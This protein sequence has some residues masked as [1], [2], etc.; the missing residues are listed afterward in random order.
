MATTLLTAVG[1]AIG[2]PVGGFVG[3]LLG[4][5]ID[6]EVF[7]PELEDPNDGKGPKID[8]FRFA[9]NA[10][11]SPMWRLVGEHNRVPGT[12]IWAGPLQVEKIE[13]EVGGKGGGGQTV[14]SYNY[15]IDLAVA[16]GEGPVAAWEEVRANNKFFWGNN[17]KFTAA[18]ADFDVTVDVVDGET[19]GRIT[20]P[21][22]GP[23]LKPFKSGLDVEIDG[24]VDSGGVNNGT[25][26][27][28]KSKK[29]LDGTSWIRY[30]NPD[31][32]AETAVQPIELEQL[33]PSFDPSK[34][35]EITFYDGTESQL[36][37]PL[38]ESVEG[39][40]MVPGFRGTAYFTIDKLALEPYGNL[41]PQWIIVAARTINE[42]TAGA[43]AQ[44]CERA[45]LT[46]AQYDVSAIPASSIVQG[47]PV[48]GTQTGARTLQPIMVAKDI[49]SQERNGVV[50]FFPRA[51]AEVVE[52]DPLDLAARPQGG[53]AETPFAIERVDSFEL[54]GRVSVKYRDVE[55]KY[56]EAMQEH[57]LR[58]K[59]GALV[60]NIDLGIVM[61]GEE[62][63]DIARRLAWLPRANRNRVTVR[64]PASYQRARENDLL[65]FTVL[66][67]PWRL[68]VQRADRGE[69]FSLVFETITE[70]PNL[71]AIDNSVADLPVDPDPNGDYIPPALQL[72]LKNAPG[73]TQSQVTT[74]GFFSAVF[75]FD[76]DAFFI[77][78]NVYRA[79][80]P[81][82][83]FFFVYEAPIAASVG[84]SST[85][86]AAPTDPELAAA[87][88]DRETTLTVEM[89]TGT[90]QSYELED[91]LAGAGRYLWGDEVIGAQRATF[92]GAGV[93]EL[94]ILL[95]GLRDTTDHMAHVAG[96]RVVHINAN[97]FDFIP[98]DSVVLGNSKVYKAV[99]FGAAEG[100]VEP[101]LFF[102]PTG[103]TV[104]PFRPY[105]LDATRTVTDDV[106][107]T[108]IRRSRSLEELFEM[109]DPMDLDQLGYTIDVYDGP[110]PDA[111][112]IVRTIVVPFEDGETATY[113]AA[114]QT[115]DGFTPGDPVTVRLRKV[116]T[117]G[118][119]A[120][121]NPTDGINI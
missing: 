41:P 109:N 5:Y 68:L 67:I 98:L 44:I 61:D 14:T 60:S 28:V 39:T 115:T 93:Y 104:R 21:S 53:D 58:V 22:G 119:A 75:P 1:T 63:R 79:P 23:N 25:Y 116:S 24:Y 81:E 15:F 6:N 118:T 45:G 89:D 11:G 106:V 19:F 103:E 120:L 20:S 84:T 59:A 73:F 18:S 10:E 38:I 78:A 96:E 110:D 36:A 42:T 105:A 9:Q 91:M 3:G 52:V 101:Q 31:A 40:G 70:R 86:V 50:H 117:F 100:D 97:G 54:P 87:F 94:S 33:K 80:T 13:E 99:A 77:G 83:V 95:R 46:S 102:G 90:L 2:G 76:P 37:S 65:T 74:L 69:D 108:W 56:Q 30:R 49:L 29:E 88:I 111:D 17:P 12:V 27:V 85:T 82:S 51:D 66:G 71:L 107:F 114:Q 35:D 55:A 26:E 112:N 7:G 72:L 113:T 92:M 34:A 8:D 47:M 4:A 16:A 64:L 62:A 121:G 32:I 43:I 48:R 57:T